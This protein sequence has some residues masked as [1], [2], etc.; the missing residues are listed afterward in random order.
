MRASKPME[1]DRLRRIP[2]VDEVLRR[3]EVARLA[4][5]LSASLLAEWV[6][7]DLSSIRAAA[8]DDAP[9]ELDLDAA[10]E[11]LPARL[12][13]RASALA[14]SP[15]RRVVNATGVLV[16][17]NLGRAPLPAAALDAVRA[18]GSSYV[19]LEFDLERGERGSLG[20]HLREVARVLFPGR[21]LL[22]VNNNAAAV[23]LV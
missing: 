15:I 19:N 3:P 7:E 20:A 5:D 13:A 1:R 14:R 4:A 10:L 8:L 22:A 23:L 9:G 21:A 17:T 11:T 18:A 12:A 16:H 2:A 6:R